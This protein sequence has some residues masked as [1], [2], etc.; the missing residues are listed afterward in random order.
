VRETSEV[1]KLPGNQLMAKE[2]LT[3]A[4]SETAV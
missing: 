3:Q 1:E 4:Y 2:L